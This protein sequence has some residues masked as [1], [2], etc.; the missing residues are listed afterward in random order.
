MDSQG[1]GRPMIPANLLADSIVKHRV[2]ADKYPF[3]HACG[4]G[5]VTAFVGNLA[6]AHRF[7]RDFI[8]RRYLDAGREAALVKHGLHGH[9]RAAG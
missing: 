8:T 6:H 2:G 4:I 7:H 1:R 5:L 9:H 3:G